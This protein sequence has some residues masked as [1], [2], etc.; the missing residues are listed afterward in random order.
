MDEFFDRNRIGVGE[1]FQQ[2]FFFRRERFCGGFRTERGGI[3]TDVPQQFA[4]DV[5]RR[6]DELC[7]MT[8]NQ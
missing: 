7:L 4:Y 8:V 3:G 1:K 5:A 6:L 2:S